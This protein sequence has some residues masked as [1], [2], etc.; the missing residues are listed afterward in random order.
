MTRSSSEMEGARLLTDLRRRGLQL[1]PAGDQLQIRPRK[2]VTNELRRTLQTHKEDLLRALSLEE[3]ILR[4]P[5]DLFERQ[6]CLI[7]VQVSW[8]PQTLWFVPG[9]KQVEVLTQRGISRG[10]IWTARELMFLWSLPS[11]DEKAVERLGLIKA[12]LDG[13][14]LSVDGSGEGAAENV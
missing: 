2:A 11:M 14:I 5:L 8:L 13:E 12:Q 4:M 3:R 10:R 7:E 9:E 1:L 6:G